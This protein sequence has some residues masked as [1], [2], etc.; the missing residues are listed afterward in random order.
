M[1]NTGRDGLEGVCNVPA[2]IA[3]GIIKVKPSTYNYI[4]HSSGDRLKAK[5]AAFAESSGAK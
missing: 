2:V 4:Q 5:L 3:T 1:C